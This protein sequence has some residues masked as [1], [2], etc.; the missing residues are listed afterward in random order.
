[1]TSFLL[2]S[3]IVIDHF[4]GVAAATSFL[5][6]HREVIA[7]S[8]I[9]RAE[10]LTGFDHEREVLA[11]AVLARLRH[12]PV[13]LE[14]ADLAAALRRENC[15]KLP[16]ALQAAIALNRHLALVTRNTK[17]FDPAQHSFVRVP[18]TIGSTRSSAHRPHG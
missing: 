16:D 6:N 2:D 9:T 8:V 17:D 10:V 18:Y 15:W 13:S 3:V 5:R 11:K 14:D 12:Y 4:N 1:M 7:I